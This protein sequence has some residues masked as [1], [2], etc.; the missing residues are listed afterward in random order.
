MSQVKERDDASVDEAGA[1]GAAGNG[2]AHV[3][4]AIVGTGFSGLGI[5]IKLKQHGDDD[6]VLLERASDLGGT[7]RDNTYPGCACDVPSHLYSFSFAPNPNWSHFY[8][9]QA[10]IW[11][12]LRRCMDRY[13]IAPHVRWNSEVQAARWDDATQRWHITTTQGALTADFLILGQGPL[14]DPALPKIPGIET[15]AGKLFHSAQWDHAHELHGERVAV[16]G[17]GASAIQFVPQIQPI[18]GHLDLYLR[19]PPWILP[20]MDHAVTPWKQGIFRALPITQRVARTTI[21][22][23]REL[24]A[25]A[26]VRRPEMLNAAVKIAAKHRAAQIADPA[27][28]AKLTPNYTL[29]CKRVLLSDDFYPAVAQPNVE[30]IADGI[31]EIRPHSIVTNDGQERA[32]D[33]LICATGFHVTDMPA[34]QY[35]FGR[36][37][38]QL[39]EAWRDGMQA[40]LGTT[41]AGFPNLFFLI[42]PNTGLGHTSMVVMME[43]QFHYILDCFRTL[44]RQNA[45]IV[46]VQPQAQAAYNAEIQQRL[47]GT[48]WQSGCASWYLDANGHN[49]TIWPG[50]TFAFRRRTRHFDA[51]HYT[52]APKRMPVAAG[53]SH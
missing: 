8:S 3:H 34:A 6:F 23:Q 26:F 39:A 20:R 49:S 32:I 18:V 27:L 7:W 47:Q 31:R 14:S 35:V 30:V 44:A 41:V 5:A 37:G 43:A 25:L 19:T 21:Y 9:P 11:A 24:T 53:V 1:H 48:V 52:L 40:Y 2:S 46:E 12:Y 38:R 28:R 4:V 45:G 13:H 16:I 50:F 22:L 33:T 42:G 17:T 10:E 51:A 29:G 36:D 15:F